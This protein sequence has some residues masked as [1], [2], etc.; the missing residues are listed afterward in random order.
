MNDSITSTED[1]M[2]CINKIH[3]IFTTDS[4]EFEDKVDSFN[5]ESLSPDISHSLTSISQF[6]R[7]ATPGLNLK[8]LALLGQQKRLDSEN[9]TKSLKFLSDV[10]TT[11]PNDQ[12]VRNKSIGIEEIGKRVPRWSYKL[13]NNLEEEEENEEESMENQKIRSRKAKRVV[14]YTENDENSNTPTST[15]IDTDQTEEVALIRYS[16]QSDFCR[17]LIKRSMRA[18]RR[19]TVTWKIFQANAHSPLFLDRIDKT[20]FF[21]FDISRMMNLFFLF[22]NWVGK[23]PEFKTSD[24]KEE[25]A[26]EKKKDEKKGE[27]ERMAIAETWDT[28][29]F[30][31]VIRGSLLVTQS[32]LRKYIV[33]PSLIIA[34]NLVRMLLFQFPDWDGDWR[35]WNREIHV[36][37]TYNGVQLSETEFPKNWLTDGIQIKI[38]FPFCLKPWHRSKLRPHHGDSMKKKGKKKNFCFLT[39]WGMETELP[40]GYPRKGPSFFKPIFK[41][42]EKKMRKAKNQFIVLRALKKRTKRKILKEKIRWI[43]KNFPFIKRIIEEFEKVNPIFLFGLRK[44]YEPN[45]NGKDSIISNKINHESTIRIRSVDWTNYSLTEKKMKDLAD[46]TTTIRNQIEKMKKDK[47]KIFLT[48][49]RNISTSETRCDDKRAQKHIWQI[50]KRRSAQLIRKWHYFM[51]SFIERIYIEIIFWIINILKINAQLFLDSRKKILNKNIS[52]YERNKEGID[53]TNKNAIH[54]IST[55]KKSLSNISNISN[56]KSQILCDLSFL[57]QAYVF[58]NLSQTQVLNKYHLGSVLKYCGKNL[59]LKDRIKD[60]FGTRRIFDA[61]SRPKKLPNSGMNEWKN[62][63]RDHYPYNLSQ[64]RW[65]RL[66]SQKWRNIVNQRCT[67]QNKDSKKDSYEKEKDQFIHFEKRKNYVVNSLSSQ[68]DQFQKHYRY[69]LFSHEY[70]HYEGRRDSYID[71]SPL[72]GDRKI[73][74]NYNTPKPE[75]FY[76]PG[77]ITISDYLGE[78]SIIDTGKNPYRKYFEWRILDFC[79]TKNID[80]EVWTDIDTGTNINK[81]TKTGTNYYQIIDKKDL[82]DITI[83]QEINP[84]NQ[85]NFFDWMGMN[86]EMPYCPISNLEPW[87]FSEFVLLYDAYKIKPWIIPIKL[88]LFNLNENENISENKNINGNPKKDLR[89]SSSNQKEYLELENRNQEEKEQLDRGNLGSYPRNQQKDLEKGYAKLNIKKH[90]KKIQ[91]KSKKEAEL[92]FFLKRYLLFQLRWNNLVSQRIINNI[93][94]YCLL[95]RLINPREI[96]ISSIQKGEVRLG[97]MLSHKDLTFTELIKRGILIIEPLRLSTKWDGQCIMYQTI[98][99][100]LVHKNKHQTNRRCREKKHVDENYFDK[101]IS[102]HGKILVD[103]DENHYDLLVPENISSPRRRRELRIVICFNSE[104]GHVVDGNPVFSNENNVKNCRQFLD[105]DKNIDTDI[106]KFIQFKLFLW[107]NYRLEDLACMNR[108]WFDTNNGSRFSMS[109]IHMYPRFRVS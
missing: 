74:Y 49:D 98:G 5:G 59:F 28:I 90:G 83:H 14:V 53:E 58:Y 25:K 2:V 19:K 9:Q 33:L 67:I 16:R 4:R 105:E 13:T 43:L 20:F 37:C 86:E 82:F 23:G 11:D 15:N 6:A 103:G 1:F 102:Q 27:N 54:F 26:K 57:S 101:S 100:S 51:K 17:D 78:E 75:S 40:F 92:D 70:I 69:D 61:K 88:L 68:K 84:S 50:S 35:D 60:H 96:A 29:P 65:S 85:K 56:K 106:N 34:K 97:I 44:V 52:N 108:Y 104:N 63:L 109:R 42:L 7:E 66:V 99:I 30:A 48:P 45:K 95:L 38:L 64:T 46:K 12:T 73:P 80:I 22:R 107:P 36:R 39:V 10:V 21:S 79:R 87:F 62:W 72:H 31:Q 81:N 91:S 89:I 94:V 8:R 3:D 24:F 41:E 76:I 77:S 32:I 55:I 47:R 18:Q 71:R 93:K